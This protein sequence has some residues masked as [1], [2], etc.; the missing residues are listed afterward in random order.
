LTETI[1]M[2]TMS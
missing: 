2:L 1:I